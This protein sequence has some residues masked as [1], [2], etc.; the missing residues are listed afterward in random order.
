MKKMTR[1]PLFC[2]LALPVLAQA[3][4]P[5]VWLQTLPPPFE[6]I[7][8][9]VSTNI[10]SSVSTNAVDPNPKG[11]P[12]LWRKPQ[13]INTYFH[14]GAAYEMRSY[15]VAGGHGHQACYDKNGILIRGGVSAG[16]ADYVSTVNS[17]GWPILSI[18]HRDQDVWPFIR[19]L[20][21]DGN[22]CEPNSVDVPTDLKR[23]MMFQGPHLDMYMKVRPALPTGTR[24]RP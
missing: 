18:G 4:N 23:P 10:F 9:R 20:Q 6:S 7:E 12:R 11:S 5:Q 17:A 3:Q 21:L 13:K 14:P 24:P 22:P 16:S 15:P 1:I 2:C 8:I 19:A